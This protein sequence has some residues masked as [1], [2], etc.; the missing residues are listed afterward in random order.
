MLSVSGLLRSAVFGC[1]V[2]ALSASGPSGS[3]W[4]QTN[5]AAYTPTDAAYVTQSSDPAVL[6]Y[7]L[8]LEASVGTRPRREPIAESVAFAAN[9]CGFL[10]RQLTGA[11]GA[12]TAEDIQVSVQECGFRPAEASPDAACGPDRQAGG[13]GGQIG[14]QPGGVPGGVT[15]PGSPVDQADTIDLIPREIPVGKWPEGMTHDGTSLWVAESGQRTIA[16]VNMATGQIVERKRVGRLPTEMTNSL[17]GSFFT[18]VATDKIVR[19]FAP[20]GDE[21]VLANLGTCPENMIFAEGNLWATVLP[22]CS[23][24][25]SQVVRVD[26]KTG[27]QARS[28]VLGEWAQA[29][30]NH[31][32]EVYVFHTRSPEMT[33]V[34]M[35]SMGHVTLDVSGVGFWAA[36]SN[37]NWVF[38]A[39]RVQASREDGLVLSFDPRTKQEVG[40]ASVSERVIQLHAD[41]NYV[42]ALGSKGTMWVFDEGSMQLLRTITPSIGPY[43]PRSMIEHQGSLLVSATQRRGDDGSILVF[44]DWQP[45]AVS[46]GGDSGGGQPGGQ[47]GGLFPIAAGSWGG[48]VRNGPGTNFAQIGSLTN[49]E[50]VTLLSNTGVMMNGYPWF[51]IRFKG[52]QR[53]HMWGGI[54][55]GTIQ[56]VPGA[57]KMCDG[58]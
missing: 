9:Q 4:G 31:S 28:A 46:G 45:F 29:V 12:P 32:G 35:Q 14:G 56:E 42:V 19:R 37:S 49:G 21:T 10:G 2:M 13:Q 5:T 26:P 48:K 52:G 22:S 50:R 43:K 53:G 36:A 54:L 1:A 18:L 16:A 25:S 6:A 24:E 57:Y 23:S 7:V 20:F 30:T 34:N 40:R 3:A 58:N 51:E 15:Q 38:G 11:N 55:C 39:G 8:C 33:V 17:D 47:N 27:A 41:D 44:D